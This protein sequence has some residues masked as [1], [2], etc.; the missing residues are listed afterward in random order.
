[1]PEQPIESELETAENARVQLTK[2]VRDLARTVRGNYRVACYVGLGLIAVTVLTVFAAGTKALLRQS[3]RQPQD[4]R[5]LWN[6]LGRR[7]LLGAAGPLAAHLTRRWL[8]AQTGTPPRDSSV[9]AS[10]SR[11][12]TDT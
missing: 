6:A 2:D 1:M 8:V 5:P 4:T 3:P 12:D 9:D 7:M 10:V 11:T